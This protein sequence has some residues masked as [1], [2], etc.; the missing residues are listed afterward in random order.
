MNLQIIAVLFI[1][2]GL[3]L[4]LYCVVEA[5]VC[6]RKVARHLARKAAEDEGEPQA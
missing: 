1:W 5:E 3:A 6:Y 4:V 2:L